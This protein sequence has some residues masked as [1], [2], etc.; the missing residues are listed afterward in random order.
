M[1]ADVEES[2]TGFD[3]DYDAA[4]FYG[5]DKEWL[6]NEVFVFLRE[7]REIRGVEFED[8]SVEFEKNTNLILDLK[9]L[10]GLLNRHAT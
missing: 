5:R 7:N 8:F 2:Q 4:Y 6:L 1:L 9:A 3:F 10:A